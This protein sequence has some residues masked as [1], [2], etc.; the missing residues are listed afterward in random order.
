MNSVLEELKDGDRWLPQT[1]ERILSVDK[2]SL[3]YSIE[4]YLSKNHS[5]MLHFQLKK[6]GF[7]YLDICTRC[8]RERSLNFLREVIL[9][10]LFVGGW[11]TKRWYKIG[12]YQ[13]KYD[14]TTDLERFLEITSK[15][16]LPQCFHSCPRPNGEKVEWHGTIGGDPLP[17]FLLNDF[18]DKLKKN[19]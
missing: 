13:T 3:P 12:K 16:D 8:G 5:L 15:L 7:L 10:L 11:I 1:A 9:E 14:Y 2:S 17:I 18:L 4:K 6:G 19:W